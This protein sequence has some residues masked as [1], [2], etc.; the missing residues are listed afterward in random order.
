MLKRLNKA[1]IL[2]LIGA[3]AYIAIELLFRGRTH[4][5]MGI[6]GG[7]LFLLLGGINNYLSWDMPLIWQCLLGAVIVTVAELAVG[8]ILNV[9]LGLGIWDYSDMQYNL[10]GQ[11]CPQFSAAWAG[12]SLVAILL[13]DWVR[14]WLF[15]EDRPHYRVFKRAAA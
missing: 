1:S 5:T 3:G 7:V 11:I 13:D 12:L 8:L 4:W 10:W 14:Y 2:F 6:M 15:G 9:W